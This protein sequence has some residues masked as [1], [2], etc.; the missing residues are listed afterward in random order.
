MKTFFDVPA[1]VK[2]KIDPNF[3]EE[4]GNLWIC[5][6]AYHDVI[7]CACCGGVFEMDEICEIVELPWYDFSDEFK[8]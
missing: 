7:I 4:E 5:G 2:F 8:E 6:I 3:C 1:Q